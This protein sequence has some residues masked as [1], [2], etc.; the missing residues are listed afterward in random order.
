MLWP[1]VSGERIIEERREDEAR[2]EQAKQEGQSVSN[3]GSHEQENM[4]DEREIDLLIRRVR[5]FMLRR[6]GELWLSRGIGGLLLSTRKC[7]LFLDDFFFLK[8][9]WGA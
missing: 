2:C 9:G 7:G 3:Y 4:T 1:E 5:D 6:V 8:K